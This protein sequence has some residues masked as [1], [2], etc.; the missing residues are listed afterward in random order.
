MKKINIAEIL[1][2]C[3]KGMKLYSP[4]CGECTFGG[5]NNDPK[6]PIIVYATDE[7]PLYFTADG[8]YFNNEDAEYLFFPSKDQRDWSKFQRP[9]VDGDII[10][11]KSKERNEYIIIF[12][13]IRNDHIHKYV[14]FAYQALYID[15]CAL[16]HLFDAEVMRLATEEEKQKL[17]QAI[18]DN[19]YKWNPETKVL[20]KY[21]KFKTGDKIRHKYGNER[22]ISFCT[23]DGYWTT[24]H[25]WISRHQQDEYR[26]VPNKF[27][28]TTL[29]PFN[30]VLVRCSSLE[31]WHID[32]FEIFDK[33]NKFP[34][35]CLHN[36]RYKEC[37]P[38][39]GNE[40]LLGTTDDCDE[41]YK[42]WK[43]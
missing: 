35:V 28:I 42:I 23:D 37:I 43:N 12:K 16:C 2:N 40:H 19:G 15:T 32:F 31:R 39:E 41:Y 18:K 38:Y 9:F 4:I 13:E 36:N 5:V 26:L 17:F 3:P 24:S 33:N 20:E 27:D 30:K 22:I 25:D 34:F 14:C 8:R 10:Y 21:I 29:K 7:T 11:V 1:K 6:Y